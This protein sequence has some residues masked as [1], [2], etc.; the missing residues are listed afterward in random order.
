MGEIKL[1]S[2]NYRV[3]NEKN[4]RLIRKSLAD[5][6]AGRS[7]LIDKNDC[8]IAGNGVYQKAQELG[9]PV[10]IVE[11]DGTELV[12]IRR[13]D[14]ATEDSRRKALALADNYT[15][16]TSV[17]DLD[18]VLEDFSIDELDAWEFS[19]SD[20]TIDDNPYIAP[21]GK[22][23]DKF[24]IPP[25]SIL[26]SRVA[27]WTQRKQA[28]LNFG[29]TSEIGRDSGLLYTRSA[30]PPHVY[31]IRNKIREKTGKDPSWDEIYEY[32]EKNNIRLMG[33]TSIFDPVLCEL[34]YR[35]FNLERGIILDPFAGGSVRGIVA[36]K[37]GMQYYGVDLRK[38]QID[39][40]Y[41]NA[42]EVLAEEYK[43]FP[44][45]CC[46]N[47]ANMDKLFDN[48][49]FDLIFSCPPYADLEVYSDDSRDLST[50][51]YCDFIVAYRDIIKK[52]C[53]MLND[54]RFAV[55]VVSEVR[56]K[57]TGAYRNFVSDTVKA[58]IDCGLSFYN[59]MIFVNKSGALAIRVA[60]Q[61]NHSRKIGRHHQNVLVF[62]K[63]DTTRIHESYPELDFSDT[64]FDDEEMNEINNIN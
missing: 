16:D 64:M 19:V 57:K 6:G 41:Q 7:I 21:A 56:D 54:N 46:D 10:R 3:H 35:W 48:D 30:Q 45:W 53:D 31:N 39:A 27:R 29:I 26:D 2:K 37:L 4:L 33:G 59:E 49:K 8:V 11:S 61:F 24:I 28:W 60:N 51:K 23:E 47:S 42:K 20:L 25:F 1:D 32:C 63:G 43:P 22:L 9:L 52:A 5:C 34:V 62:Y 38:E 12:A 50:M 15:S 17:F 13:I 40:N 44:Y 36:A 58:F 55:F 14:L 18:V